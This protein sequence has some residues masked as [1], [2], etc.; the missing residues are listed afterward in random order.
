MRCWNCCGIEYEG[1]TCPTCGFSTIMYNILGDIQSFPVKFINRG[2]EEFHSVGPLK[3]NWPCM[4]SYA[5]D[6]IYVKQALQH[7]TLSILFCRP[8]DI[9]ADTDFS[10]VLCEDP[11]LEFFKFHNR[12]VETGFYPDMQEVLI[13]PGTTVGQGAILG[14]DGGRVY[15]GLRVLHGGSVWVGSDS[16]IGA[17]TVVVWGIWGN[18]TVIGDNCFIGN[19][20]NIGHGCIIE[21]DVMILPGAILCGSVHVGKGARISPGAVISNGVRIGA[22]AFVTLGAVVTKDVK[23]GER[24][25]GNFAVEHSRWLGFV[26]GLGREANV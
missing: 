19:L 11:A 25:S 15:K 17:N 26:K 12:L 8:E 4:V 2:F 6:E 22:G 23:P 13:G 1:D 14:V 20:V 18:P 10:L 24:V 5:Q 21:N 16:F 3:Y 7:P 9:P